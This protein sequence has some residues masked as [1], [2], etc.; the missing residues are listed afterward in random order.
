MIQ[1]VKYIKANGKDEGT[2]P[3]NSTDS[4][5]RTMTLVTVTFAP[6][7]YDDVKYIRYRMKRKKGADREEVFLVLFHRAAV[8]LFLQCTYSSTVPIT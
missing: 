5:Q 6:S 3:S 8:L 4:A 2:K 1:V 7:P